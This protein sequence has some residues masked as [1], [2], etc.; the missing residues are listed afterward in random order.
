M[1]AVE[2]LGS[3]LTI[4]MIAHRL[5]TL[6]YCDKVFEIKRGMAFL[7]KSFNSI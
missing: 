7:K 2:G 1:S 6:E 5:S 4:I 3:D